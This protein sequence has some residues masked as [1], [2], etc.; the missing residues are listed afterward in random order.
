MVGSWS[1]PWIFA[2]MIDVYCWKTPFCKVFASEL[3]AA[4]LSASRSA[5]S[6]QHLHATELANFHAAN[7]LPSIGMA[8]RHVPSAQWCIHCWLPLQ[9]RFVPW[10]LFSVLS[11]QGGCGWEGWRTSS[12]PLTKTSTAV[13]VPRNL[14]FTLSLVI[15][16]TTMLKS[17]IL[18]FITVKGT[19][20]TRFWKN[21]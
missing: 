13:H 11:W 10:L 9:V 15:V 4:H 7:S 21:G 6:T 17:H 18:S 5:I 14:W 16:S 20:K 19:Y 12:L 8:W 3:V 2:P 1:M